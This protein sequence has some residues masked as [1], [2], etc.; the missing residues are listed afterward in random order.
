MSQEKIEAEERQAQDKATMQKKEAQVPS[1]PTEPHSRAFRYALKRHS[2]VN[3]LTNYVQ[4][5]HYR[6]EFCPVEVRKAR[7]G[8]S[9][10]GMGFRL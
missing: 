5:G 6:A 1:T 4:S 7:Y 2:Q 8:G 3:S 10:G 9:V